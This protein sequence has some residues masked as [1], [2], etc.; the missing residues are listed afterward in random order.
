LSEERFF[1]G[2]CPICFTQLEQKPPYDAG[3][4]HNCGRAWWGKD[5]FE[6]EQRLLS[7]GWLPPC[8]GRKTWEGKASSLFL[9][10][11]TWEM[12]AVLREIDGQ[13]VRLILDPLNETK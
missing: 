2:K 1:R 10:D 6:Y 7:A 12:A 8:E 9:A 11:S 5:L 13:R 3:I 4:C